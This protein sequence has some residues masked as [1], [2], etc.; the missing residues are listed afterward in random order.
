MLNYRDITERKQAEELLHNERLLLRTL[1]DNIPYSIYSKDIACRKTLANSAEVH[2]VRA[3]SEKEVLGKDDF[4]FYPKEMADSF[5]AD[6]QLVLQTGKPVLNREEYIFNEN[7]EKRWLLTSKLPL[8]NL[9]GQIIGLVGI[10]HDITVRKQMEEELKQ[11]SAR[12]AL[13]TRAGGVGVW[14]YDIDNNIVVWDDQMIA[15][16]GLDKKNFSGDYEAWQETLHPDDRVRGDQ[17]IQMAI[18]GKKEFNT[19][20][21]VV[22]FIYT[23]R[24]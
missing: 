5:F 8:R 10:G 13:A 15:L 2:I 11:T 12:L 16:Y 19:E 4:A 6:D 24:I 3:K 7:E 22:Y 17:E 9:D 23:A 1:I 18:S 20:F 14:D 21:R